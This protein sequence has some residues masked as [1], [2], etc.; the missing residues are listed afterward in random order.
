MRRGKN[1]TFTH[2]IWW[3]NRAAINAMAFEA[4]VYLPLFALILLMGAALNV[5]YP[6]KWEEKEEGP[7]NTSKRVFFILIHP[8][9]QSIIILLLVKGDRERETGEWMHD[10][11]RTQRQRE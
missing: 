4:G 9:G 2:K 11:L 8:I 6:L 7:I 3:R 1:T 5:Q 10:V